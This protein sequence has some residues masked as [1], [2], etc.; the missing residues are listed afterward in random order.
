MRNLMC[1]WKFYNQHLQQPSF[2]FYQVEKIGDKD[3]ISVTNAELCVSAL[4]NASQMV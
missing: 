4:E 1:M 3:L 2:A